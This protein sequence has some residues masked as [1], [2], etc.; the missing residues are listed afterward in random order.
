MTAS[1]RR[2]DI[3]ASSD[4]QS[5]DGQQAT[6]KIP[7]QFIYSVL[8]RSRMNIHQT[9]LQR[10]VKLGLL[11]MVGVNMIACSSTM[12]WKEEVKLHDGQVILVQRHFNLGGYLTLDASERTP[13]DETISFSLP[14][15]KKTILWKTEFNDRVPERN[16]LSPLLLGVVGGIPYLA[17]SPAGCIAYNKW[18]RPNPPYILFKYVNDAWQQISL[19]E[20]PTVL[21]HANL[22][23]KPAA[24]LLKPYYNVEAAKAEREDGNVSDYD[25]TILREPIRSAGLGCPALIRTGDGWKSRDWFEDQPTREACLKFCEREKVSAESCPCHSIFKGAK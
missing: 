21:V 15:S 18:G 6:L 23:G 12:E 1:A 7:I 3:H 24:S 2:A 20:F 14:D 5:Q 8:Q 17:T 16:S 13:L 11:L 25:K 22:I 19:Q 9:I 4:K 10:I